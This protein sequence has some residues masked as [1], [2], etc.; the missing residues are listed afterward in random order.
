MVVV[1]GGTAVVA[2]SIE[3]V[4][5]FTGDGDDSLT[6]SNISGTDVT[7]NTVRAE[8]GAGDDYA[9]GAAGFRNVQ[10]LGEGGDDTL[11]GSTLKRFH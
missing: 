1:N 10:F 8:L 5:V 7:N 4:D 9:S 11:I 6:V 3:T 2:T